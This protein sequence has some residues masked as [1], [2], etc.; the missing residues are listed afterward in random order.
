VPLD[1]CCAGHA[2]GEGSIRVGKFHYNCDVIGEFLAETREFLRL[3]D[4]N[5]GS[6]CGK[7]LVDVT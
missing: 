5:V 4:G 2:C 1:F 3:S 6:G 7:D